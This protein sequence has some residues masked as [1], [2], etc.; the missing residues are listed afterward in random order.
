[1]QPEDDS[2]KVKEVDLKAKETV[3]RTPIEILTTEAVQSLLLAPPPSPLIGCR[4]CQIVP[5]HFGEIL[6]LPKSSKE[7]IE[8][9]LAEE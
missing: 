5:T 7:T 9:H 8:K 2:T 3:G 4:L 1:V 6:E